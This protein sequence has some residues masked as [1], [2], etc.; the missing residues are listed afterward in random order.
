MRPTNIYATWS[1][2]LYVRLAFTRRFTPICPYLIQFSIPSGLIITLVFPGSTRGTV[3]G[4]LT[5]LVYLQSLAVSLVLDTN[6]SN[7]IYLYMLCDNINNV[8]SHCPVENHRNLLY[9]LLENKNA[10]FS[11]APKIPQHTRLAQ[12]ISH[13]DMSNNPTIHIFS[14]KH[15]APSHTRS[16]S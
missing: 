10:F 1:S 6:L 4:D 16:R 5:M 2:H 8:T 11:S 12:T 14:G 7:N 13:Y 3:F 9:L 15:T